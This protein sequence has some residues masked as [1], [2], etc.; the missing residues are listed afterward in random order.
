M[1]SN[2]WLKDLSSAERNLV[3]EDLQRGMTARNVAAK[4]HLTFKSVAD[5]VSRCRKKGFISR[6]S[7]TGEIL[8]K[9]QERSAFEF[10]RSN[11]YPLDQAAAIL[12][13]SKVRLLKIIERGRRGEL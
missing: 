8:S 2:R 13:I 11:M 5:F 10:Y 1:S 6:D 4:H 9:E 3:F 12:C 7:L